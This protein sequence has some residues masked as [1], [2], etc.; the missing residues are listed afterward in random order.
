MIKFWNG[1]KSNSRQLYELDLVTMLFNNNEIDNDCTDHPRAEDEGN[2]FNAGTDILV[3]VAG[4]Q[5]FLENTFLELTEPLCKDLLGCRILIIREQDRAKFRNIDDVTLKGLVAGI[6]ETWADAALF[7]S[8]HYQVLEKGSLADVFTYLKQGLC[9]YVSLGANEVQDVFEQHAQALGEL[10][11]ENEI[12]LYYPMPLVFYTHPQRPD[13]LETLAKRLKLTQD[14]GQF[15]AIFD[16]HYGKVIED[17]NL[18]KRRFFQLS[19]PSLPTH[20]LPYTPPYS[21]LS[22]NQE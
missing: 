16:K 2:V 19:N 22:G 15:D 14:N 13:L 5:K 12:V 3:T 18:S 10:T 8:N 20:F 17:M 11:I 21:I 6:P 1:N 4:N 9:D 7:R